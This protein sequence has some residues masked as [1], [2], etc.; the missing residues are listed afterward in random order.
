V[1]CLRLGERHP[2]IFNL[3]SSIFNPNLALDNPGQHHLMLGADGSGVLIGRA[4]KGDHVFAN[5]GH[6]GDFIH[7]PVLGAIAGRE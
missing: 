7:Q 4:G 6:F 5:I 1:Y 3:Q 2:Q